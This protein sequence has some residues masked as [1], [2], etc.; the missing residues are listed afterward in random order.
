MACYLK[1]SLLISAIVICWTYTTNAYII[2][3]S[4]SLTLS[5][6]YTDNLNRTTDEYKESDFIR[7][8]SP[9][10]TVGFEEK[11]AG[12]SVT[13]SP[14][15][16]SY[17]EFDENDTWRHTVRGNAWS[18]LTG[19]TRVDVFGSYVRTEEPQAL[20]DES[21]DDLGFQPLSDRTM[22]LVYYVRTAGFRMTHEYGVMNSTVV[23][24]EFRSVLYDQRALSEDYEGHTPFIRMIYWPAPNQWGLEL[25]FSFVRGEYAE[26]R[27]DIH[28]YRG[29]LHIT[30]QFSR[31]FDTYLRYRHS[32]ITYDGDTEPYQVYNPSIGMHY[33]LFQDTT[34][35]FSIGYFYQDMEESE[36]SSGPSGTADLEDRWAGGMG[37]TNISLSGGYDV[38]LL[39]TED[40]GFS[41]YSSADVTVEYTFTRNLTGEISG[42]V[43][44]DRYESAGSAAPEREDTTAE[45]ATGLS[46]QITSWIS[47]RTEFSRRNLDSNYDAYEYTENRVFLEFTFAPPRPIRRVH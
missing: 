37:V 27:D 46:W 24:Y 30:R 23:G 28:E 16:S 4:P 11:N 31:R 19:N 39:D 35:G 7:T 13:Y 2:T 10:F 1:K 34:V 29:D 36:D 42:S 22:R 40:L 47:A 9:G 17:A 6:E 5:G 14:A 18:E 20:E 25:G 32:K 33:G 3:F 21:E 41:V 45:I 26:E 15:Y 12:F 38:S 43:R 44:W 8:I